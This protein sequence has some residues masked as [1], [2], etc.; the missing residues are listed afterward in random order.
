MA[1]EKK[2][3]LEFLD[4]NGNYVPTYPKTSLDQVEGGQSAIDTAKASAIDTAKANADSTYPKKDGTGA[5]G[6]WAISITGNAATSSACSGNSATATKATKATTAE[7]CTGNSAT[8]TLATTANTANAVAFIPDCAASHNGIFRGKD[9]TSYFTSGEM[10]KA[11][12]A[13]TFKDIYIGDYINVAMTVNGT[14]I[15]TVKWIVAHCDYHLYKGDTITTM[16]D[17][18]HVVMVPQDVLDVNI[19]MNSDNTSV[20]GYIATE[21]WTTTLP[22]YVTAIQSAFGTDHVLSHRELLTNSISADSPSAAGAGWTG[23]SNGWEWYDVS[24]NLMN[25]PMVYGTTAFGSSGFDVGDCCEQLALFKLDTSA[26]IA[27]YRGN[28]T[29]RKWYWLRV[30]ASSSRFANA[31]DDGIA[32]WNDASLRNVWSGVRPYF[33]LH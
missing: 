1:N 2:G 28:R 13:G 20:G 4:E 15:G 33:L 22:L 30:V 5:T 24:A 26:T 9:L 32:A 18:H 10:S 12:A 7:A 6:T 17:A 3:T 27:G 21:M 16:T 31:H 14:S 23:S 19:R 8:A 25:E 29:D 11:I